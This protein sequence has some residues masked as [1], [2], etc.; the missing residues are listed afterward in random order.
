MHSKRTTTERLHQ[1]MDRNGELGR[2]E[3]WVRDTGV[4]SI[5]AYLIDMSSTSAQFC[6]DTVYRIHG[7]LGLSK[8]K[9]VYIKQHWFTDS[10]KNGNASELNGDIIHCCVTTIYSGS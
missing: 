5:N 1:K 3:G 8:S 9:Y 6:L 2:G 7:V 4:Y 10:D